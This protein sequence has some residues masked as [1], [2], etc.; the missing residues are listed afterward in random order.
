MYRTPRRVC[1]WLGV[2]LTQ[3]AT[4]LRTTP[5]GGLLPLFTRLSHFHSPGKHVFLEREDIHGGYMGEGVN[6]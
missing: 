1:A 5:P 3:Q 2:G 4:A 6:L